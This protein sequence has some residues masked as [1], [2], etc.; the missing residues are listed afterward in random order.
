MQKKIL[1]TKDGL[2][3]NYYKIG[4]GSEKVLICNAPGMSIKLWVPI[5]NNLKD[6]FTFFGMEYRGFPT[7][8]E[9]LPAEYYGFERLIEDCLEIIKT[10]NIKSMHLF[11]WCV[12][13]K[14]ALKLYNTVGSKILS[15]TSLNCAY[16]KHD[17]N[18][19]GAY[20]QLMYNVKKRVDEDKTY[21]NR[22][23]KIIKKMGT[24]PTTDFLEIMGEKESDS[25]SLD[26][27]EHLDSQSPLAGLSFYLIDTPTALLNYMNIYLSFG[28]VNV[29]DTIKSISCP[30]YIINGTDDN[31]V[32]Y[33]KDDF[34]LINSN[35]NIK[36]D[37][38][39]KGTHFIMV[40]RPRKVS[41]L[42]MDNFE[43]IRQ[44]EKLK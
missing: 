30:F 27:Y 28:R 26:L 35:V 20:A 1:K 34:D 37:S 43:R 25:P 24:I 16:K 13:S 44:V 10:E 12:G 42:I 8:E 15:V 38:I 29:I 32:R 7:N 6:K 31:V 3:L 23:V 11:S 14:L 36:Y 4:T 5:I 9:E 39:D 33:H 21:V 2:D 17:K 19:L 18:N 22:M 41:R 40:D